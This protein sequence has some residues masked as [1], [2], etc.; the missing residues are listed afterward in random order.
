V[1]EKLEQGLLGPDGSKILYIS[2][3][4]FLNRSKR[5]DVTNLSA[6]EHIG[7][8]VDKVLIGII[9]VTAR[10]E[11]LLQRVKCLVKNEAMRLGR[12]LVGQQISLISI[13]NSNAVGLGKVQRTFATKKA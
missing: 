1:L 3:S 2:F 12:S 8:Q 10:D 7:F 4:I 11:K 13:S 9:C 6:L 5:V